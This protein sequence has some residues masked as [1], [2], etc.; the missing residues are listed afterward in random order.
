MLYTTSKDRFR[1]ELDG[2]HSEIQATD[3]TELDLEVLQE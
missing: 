3:P 1:R 2:I